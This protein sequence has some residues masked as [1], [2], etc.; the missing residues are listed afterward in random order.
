MSKKLISLLAVSAVAAAGAPAGTIIGP[1]EPMAWRF[2]HP[3]AQ[4]LAG[5]DFRKL[6]E[7]GDGR[8]IRNSL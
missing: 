2:A 1:S 3:E 8:Q 5:V 7:T 4:I 6:A